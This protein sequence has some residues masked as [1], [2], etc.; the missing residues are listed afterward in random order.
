M[1]QILQ[2]RE[3][4]TDY[5]IGQRSLGLINCSIKNLGSV[6][7]RTIL[8][9]SYL[10]ISL[11]LLLS[12]NSICRVAVAMEEHSE[13]NPNIPILLMFHSKKTSLFLT[14]DL[15]MRTYVARLK[16]IT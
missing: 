8:I 1:K 6:T 5:L 11:N 15:K 14:L 16:L 3:K 9:N 7:F 12:E 13:V 10:S 2:K 4:L